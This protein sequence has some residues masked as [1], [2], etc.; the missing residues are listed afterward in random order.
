M[1]Q[2]DRIAQVTVLYSM[3]HQSKMQSPT[4]LKRVVRG[5]TSAITSLGIECRHCWNVFWLTGARCPTNML[6]KTAVL[7]LGFSKFMYL[8][9]FLS[10]LLLPEEI[11]SLQHISGVLLRSKV[12]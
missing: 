4:C 6:M 2:G 3:H 9:H 12:V 1:Q 11:S 10:S 8:S 7:G 5:R